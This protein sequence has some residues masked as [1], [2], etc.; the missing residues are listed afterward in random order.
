VHL[1]SALSVLLQSF[2]DEFRSTAASDKNKVI[3]GFPTFDSSKTN[4]SLGYLSYS[5][6]FAGW[7][8]NAAGRYTVGRAIL[9]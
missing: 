5:G 7:S 4:A 1:K 6:T 8:D 3:S 9:Q 2:N